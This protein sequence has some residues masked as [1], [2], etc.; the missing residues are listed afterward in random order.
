VVAVRGRGPD[1]GERRPGNGRE[2]DEVAQTLGAA[3]RARRTELGMTKE[4]LADRVGVRQAEV[5]RLE[6]G[7]VALPRR[8][9]LERIAAALGL[10]TGEL[11]ARSGWAGA[12]RA[13]AEP[14]PSADP[15]PTPEPVPDLADRLAGS[16]PAVPP[17]VA[18]LREALA[19]AQDTEARTRALVAELDARWLG[20]S[21]PSGGGPPD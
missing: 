16:V 6:R 11:L 10:A 13:L 18:R 15:L 14:A 8:P 19:A 17:S 2:E 7:R 9:R 20:R 12:D 1:R 5:S 4:E 21:A 3:I